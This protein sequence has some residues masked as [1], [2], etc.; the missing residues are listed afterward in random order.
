M[1]LRERLRAIPADVRLFLLLVAF[2]LPL[3]VL[4]T[5]GVRWMFV[6]GG[7]YVEVARNVRDGKGLVTNLS[8]YH[9]GFESFPYPTALYPL[10]PLLLGYLAKLG[11]L[12]TLAHWL[13]AALSFTAVTGAFLFGRRLWPEPPFPTAAPAFHAGHALAAM[14]AVHAHFVYFTSLPYT[15]GLS[16]T[17]LLFFLW[18]LVGRSGSTS[19]GWAVELGVWV[20]ALYFCRSQFLLVPIA[21]GLALAARVVVGPHRGKALVHALVTGAVVG[22]AIG[23]WFLHVRTFVPDASLVTLLRFD[24]IQAS[25]ILDPL[26]VLVERTSLAA[27]ARDTLEG[28]LLAWSNDRKSSYTVGFRYAHWALPLA[29]PFL[30]AAGVRFLRAHGL[31]GVWSAARGEA[32]FAWAVVLLIAGGGL[33]SIHLA[34]KQF[35]GSWYFGQRQ[36]L[37]C[38]LAFFLCVGWL[39]RSRRALPTMLG[40][41]VLAASVVPGVRAVWEEAV[42]EAGSIRDPN[43]Q[44]ELVRWFKRNASPEKP[45]VVAMAGSDV[46]RVGWRTSGVGFHMVYNTTSYADLLDMTDRL[47]ATHFFYP[48]HS[49][50][51]WRFRKESAGQLERDFQALPDKPNGHT[52]LVRRK[53]APAPLPP[54]RVVVVGVDGASWKVMAPMIERGELPTF[55]ALQLGGAS[56]LNFDTLDKTASPVVWTSVA[57]GQPPSK[58]GVEDYTQE[59]P[60]QGKVPITSDA[61]KVPALWDLASRGGK[62]VTAINWWASWPSEEVRGVIVSDHANPAAAGWMEGRYY[63]ADPAAL[64]AM[65]KDTWPPELAATL[66]P[67]WIDPNAFPLD[68]LDARGGFSDGQ[69]ALVAEAPFNQ[70]NTY[71]W[72]KT[73]YAVD[74]P[75]WQIA[76][77]QLRTAPNDL[78]MLYLRGPDPIQHYAWDTI[79]P[80]K[81]KSEPKHLERDRG[82]VQG[83][84]RFVDTFL[85]DLLAQVGPDTTLIVLSD[86]GAEPNPELAHKKSERPGGHTR[87]AKGV[88][89]VYG[90]H[91]RAGARIERAGP[92]DIAPTVMWALGLP[93]ADDLPGRV[94]AEAFTEDFRARRGRVRVDTW[95]TREAVPEATA[96]PADATMMEQ[97]RGLGYIE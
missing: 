34:H 91:V 74:R 80:L 88:L 82:V 24:Q 53:E 31:R 76:L 27:T 94:L 43:A 29:L 35:N 84:Y 87:A 23:G 21:V 6:D 9:A 14:L 44:A 83:V 19:L 95:G 96:S 41:A 52:I 15:E 54:Q 56:Q 7:L 51:S 67:Y 5:L 66:A 70:R 16:W 85:A 28:V 11:D 40:V 25:N 60:G 63:T 58:H 49:T 48:E 61:R 37:V 78:T 62:S 3:R 92:L 47:G 64:A 38:I 12:A 71:S 4:H 65:N 33:L 72:L 73:F 57:T 89:F 97:L 36:S 30:A 26:D 2:L 77:D 86:H 22:G 79:E 59:L 8:L 1:N 20:S 32:A 17:L 46:N 18:R 68:E 93:V 45:L 69:L 75:H 39:I 90:P 10:W 13:P 42:S 81:Y 55:R 50:R